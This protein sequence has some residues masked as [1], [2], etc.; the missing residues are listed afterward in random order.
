MCQLNFGNIVYD[1]TVKSITT[2]QK[3]AHHISLHFFLRPSNL[4]VPKVYS[5]MFYHL[6]LPG[7]TFFSFFLHKIL[8]HWT[9]PNWFCI[10][11]HK[12][13][14]SSLWHGTLHNDKTP[15]SLLQLRGIHNNNPLSDQVIT[16]KSPLISPLLEE[17]P[18]CG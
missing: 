4:T 15:L 2:L 16:N 9:I 3:S 1:P 11:A 6:A 5:T 12:A 17:Q 13:V 10:L 7:I 8:L 18:P 14:C